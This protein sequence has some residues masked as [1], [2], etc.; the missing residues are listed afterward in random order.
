MPSRTIR[1]AVSV[2]I[3]DRV[4]ILRDIASAVADLGGNIFGISQTVVAGNFTV[5]L[6]AEFPAA[7]PP[8]RVRDAIRTRF[9]P[10]QASVAVRRHTAPPPAGVRHGDGDLFIVTLSGPDRPGIL[11]AVTAFLAD[12]G[13]NIEDWRVVFGAHGVTQVGEV[14][15]PRHLDLKQVQDDLRQTLK[16]LGQAASLQQVNIFRATNEIG[17]I[18][19]LLGE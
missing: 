17:P 1:Y 13:I 9:P 6:A 2:L 3:A 4:G 10:D 14:T 12:R 5:A 18:K 16:P 8:E 15:M 11:Q 7:V 19:H